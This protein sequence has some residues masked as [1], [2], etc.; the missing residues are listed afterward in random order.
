VNCR[1]LNPVVRLSFCGGRAGPFVW[2][3][4]WNSYVNIRSAYFVLS[5]R[6]NSRFS[7]RIS[8]I[9]CLSRRNSERSSGLWLSFWCTT[10]WCTVR[11]RS[12]KLQALSLQ[13]GCRVGPCCQFTL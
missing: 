2:P 9:F 10:D 11:F 5:L 12:Y 6:L 3:R 4:F 7:N 13:A 1:F 8:A